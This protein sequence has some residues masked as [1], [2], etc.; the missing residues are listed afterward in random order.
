MKPKS[1]AFVIMFT[2]SAVLLFAQAVNATFTINA[3]NLSAIRLASNDALTDELIR[4]YWID[5]TRDIRDDEPEPEIII[6][7][8]EFTNSFGLESKAI[9]A[10][11]A[12]IDFPNN[13]SDNASLIRLVRDYLYNFPYETFKLA[14]HHPGINSLPQ[15]PVAGEIIPSDWDQTVTSSSPTMWNTLDD[16]DRARELGYNLIFLSFMADMLY[17]AHDPLDPEYANKMAVILANLDDLK[18]WVHSSFYGYN[19]DGTDT[20]ATRGW[21]L[22]L[23]YN[24]PDSFSVPPKGLCVAQNCGAA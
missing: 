1:Y 4:Q 19:L 2:V 13:T 10:Y 9:N 18:D 14:I 23:V 11:K 17:Y 12:V 5:Y 16:Y 6:G 22:D 20:W 24:G 15:E 21:E 3:N 8:R 7:D